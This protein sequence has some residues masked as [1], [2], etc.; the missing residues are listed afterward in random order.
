MA[1]IVN[2]QCNCPNCKRKNMFEEYHYKT[3]EILREC[4]DCGYYFSLF[5][6]DGK[7]VE[8]ENKKPY[9]AYT[10]ITETEGSISGNIKNKKEYNKM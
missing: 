5:L 4:P 7:F 1:T 10:I 2:Y 3:G 6:E 9:C 8:R